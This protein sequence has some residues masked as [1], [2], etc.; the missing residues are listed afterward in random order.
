MAKYE[1]WNSEDA[2]LLGA[3]RLK[4]VIH[5]SNFVVDASRPFTEA[6]IF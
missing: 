4:G 1:K 5:L 3:S 6:N 2:E